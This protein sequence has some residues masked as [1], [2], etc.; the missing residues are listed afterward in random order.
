MALYNDSANKV[1]KSTV[2]GNLKFNYWIGMKNS[3]SSNN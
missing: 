1:I 3:H 2:R